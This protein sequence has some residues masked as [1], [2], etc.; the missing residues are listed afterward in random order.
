MLARL[1][2][3]AVAA[4]LST[5]AYAQSST[6]SAT[7]SSATGNSAMGSSATAGQTTQ[8]LPQEI[9][10]KLKQDGFS[11]IKIVPG[12]FLVSAKDKSGDPVNMVIGPHSMMMLTEVTPSNGSSMSSGRSAGS[13]QTNSSGSK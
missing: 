12:S 7:G 9:R 8:A 5:A 11:N 6:S 3:A 4:T 1:L 13:D 10:S 2:V